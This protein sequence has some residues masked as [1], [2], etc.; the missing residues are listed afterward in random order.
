MGG[1]DPP[2]GKI[3]R[4]F[5]VVVFVRVFGFLIDVQEYSSTAVVAV[6]WWQAGGTA[7]Y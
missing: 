4:H 5:L 6:C 1:G 2:L 7:F 3:R